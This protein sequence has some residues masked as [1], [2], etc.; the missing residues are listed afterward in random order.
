[1]LAEGAFAVTRGA[2][3]S[4]IATVAEI[5]VLTKEVAILCRIAGTKADIT[6]EPGRLAIAIAAD[7]IALPGC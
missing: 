5:D 4:P 2:D 7:E 6:S 1:V 3:I